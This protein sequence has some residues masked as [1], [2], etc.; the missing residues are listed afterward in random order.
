MEFVIRT[1]AE[2]FLND[3][4]AQYGPKFLADILERIDHYARLGRQRLHQE[5]LLTFLPCKER[6]LKLKFRGK[7]LIYLCGRFEGEI[8]VVSHGIVKNY[9]GTLRRRDIELAIIRTR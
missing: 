1:T 9:D 2:N 5:G 6:V 7:P 4:E 3:M 8:F